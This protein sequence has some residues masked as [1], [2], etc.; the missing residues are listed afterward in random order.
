[1]GGGGV[2]LNDLLKVAIFVLRSFSNNVADAI[3][4]FFQIVTASV[5]LPCP[6]GSFLIICVFN[7][8]KFGDFDLPT[9]L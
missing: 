7:I 9:M 2:E 5:Y 6:W 1:V 4:F 8:V 3:Q